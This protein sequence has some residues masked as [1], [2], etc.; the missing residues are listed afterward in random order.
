MVVRLLHPTSKEAEMPDTTKSTS[1]VSGD[2][3]PDVSKGAASGQPADPTVTETLDMN[4]RNEQAAIEENQKRL[5]AA[6]TEGQVTVDDDR[7]NA[8][9]TG[10]TTSK[11]TDR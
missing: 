5:D 1:K 6:G 2:I 8:K 7:E 3:S 9:D 10:G 11:S 4:T